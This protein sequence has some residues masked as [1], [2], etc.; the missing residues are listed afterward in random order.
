MPRY[1]N[2]RIFRTT[3]QSENPPQKT[4]KR[5]FQVLTPP[6]SFAANFLTIIYKNYKIIVFYQELHDVETMPAGRLIKRYDSI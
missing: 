6:I 2:K 1:N 5:D 4:R 3:N